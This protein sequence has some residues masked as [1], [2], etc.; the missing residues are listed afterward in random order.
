MQTI[1]ETQTFRY[2]GTG[3]TREYT[4]ARYHRR[5]PW[6]AGSERFVIA[7]LRDM[8]DL[9]DMINALRRQSIEG[10]RKGLLAQWWEPLT[11]TADSLRDNGRELEYYYLEDRRKAL[12]WKSAT[13]KLLQVSALIGEYL[14]ESK[15]EYKRKNYRGVGIYFEWIEQ[16]ILDMREALTTIP[17][18]GDVVQQAEKVAR[19]ALNNG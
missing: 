18:E 19:E 6:P 12:A 15:A 7:A 17:F 3:T 13:K 10:R 16:H 2:A 9:E 8:A 14:R 11:E 4:V 5:Q 1:Y